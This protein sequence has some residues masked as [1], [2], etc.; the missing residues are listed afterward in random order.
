MYLAAVGHEVAL[1][2]GIGEERDRRL[3]VDENQM[4]EARELDGGELGEIGDPLD[5]GEA[6]AALDPG[7][8]D[9][10]E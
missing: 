4:L 9:L 5:V 3:G 2:A 8:E 1:L 10:G 6:G 7:R